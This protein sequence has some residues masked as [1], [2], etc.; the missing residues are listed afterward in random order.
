MG[1]CQADDSAGVSSNKNRWRRWVAVAVLMVFA[2]RWSPAPSGCKDGG[3]RPNEVDRSCCCEPSPTKN[4]LPMVQCKMDSR[5]RWLFHLQHA[6]FS[7]KH[8]RKASIALAGC[9]IFLLACLQGSVVG[10]VFRWSKTANSSDET[11]MQ[12]SC[13]G[14]ECHQAPSF[15]TTFTRGALLSHICLGCS[16][17]KSAGA[18]TW[19][20][21]EYP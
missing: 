21:E 4:L 2:F 7:L 20:Q 14:G 10:F 12:L 18:R 6:Y 8:R 19:A 16:F 13:F 15:F 5:L 1:K 3:S 9:S 11:N 17:S